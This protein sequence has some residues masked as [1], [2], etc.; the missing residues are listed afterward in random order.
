[1]I[2]K[3]KNK[4]ATG[5]EAKREEIKTVEVEQEYFFPDHQLT[6]K[7]KNLEEAERKLQEIIANK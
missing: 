6:I 2:E 3:A 7:A 5:G 1:M 4:S